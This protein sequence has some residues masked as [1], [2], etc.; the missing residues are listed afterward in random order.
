M[1]FTF[2]VH[3]PQANN[4]NVAVNE[5][6]GN[7]IVGLIHCIIMRRI[8][9]L[10]QTKIIMVNRCELKSGRSSI[11]QSCIRIVQVLNCNE[12]ESEMRMVWLVKSK[13]KNAYRKQ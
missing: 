2:T 10:E 8:K 7:M 6:I 4:L 9:C 3:K 13:F 11:S 5:R 12:Y 1:I